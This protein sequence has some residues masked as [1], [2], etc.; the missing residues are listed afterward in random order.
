MLLLPVLYLL[1]VAGT[2]IAVAIYAVSGL[3]IIKGGSFFLSLLLYIGPLFAG[4]VVLLFL[5]KP[6]FASRVDHVPFHL[7]R[8]DE[9]PHLYELTE[10]LARLVGA[11]LPTAIYVSAR[12]N[13]SAGLHTGLVRRLRGRIFLDVGLP[14]VAGLSFL[15]FAGV[16]SHEFGHVGQ[17]GAMRLG[18]LIGAINAWFARAV[19]EEDA[20]DEQL[21][22]WFEGQ[23]SSGLVQLPA[24]L[25]RGAV[26]MTRRV[27]WLLMVAG[28]GLS[29]LLSR[30]M[31]RDADRY[32]ARLVGGTTMATT[33]QKLELLMVADLVVD[34]EIETGEL[35]RLPDDLPALVAARARALSPAVVR[36]IRSAAFSQETGFFDTHPSIR[37]RVESCTTRGPR[38]RE[39]RCARD[40]A[41]PG[42]SRTLQ[43]GHAGPLR[44]RRRARLRLHVGDR[45][46]GEET[47]EI[48]GWR[49]G[50]RTDSLFPGPG[51]RRLAVLSEKA[52]A[53]AGAP[54][55]GSRTQLEEFRSRLTRDLPAARE[56]D[57]RCSRAREIRRLAH[58]AAALLVAGIPINPRY[59]RLQAANP[60][61]LA[62][63]LE[64]A[65][66]MEQ[67]ALA[68]LRAYEQVQR[69]RLGVAL[70]PAASSTSLS[71]LG[72]LRRIDDRLTELQSELGCFDVLAAAQAELPGNESVRHHVEECRSRLCTRV[73]EMASQVGD[74]NYVF[75]NG[76]GSIPLVKHLVPVPPRQGEGSRAARDFLSRASALHGRL[77]GELAL[78]AEAAETTAGLPPLD[79]PRGN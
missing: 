70:L 21:V 8:R 31:E 50:G 2:G 11:P 65:R 72:A 55:R 76:S 1:I 67:G 69:E 19:Y 63:A 51:S 7:V 44:S 52:P 46:A 15:Q 34:D 73:E 10:R 24:L 39:D 54:P 62:A 29:C 68:D 49:P 43:A 79:P 30:E 27:L 18:R 32:E 16:M 40:R 71:I 25:A 64:R 37:D 77:L 20:W 5:L 36:R 23:S 22:D 78:I 6:L 47:R 41:L 75:P 58:Q 59:F 14:L 56:A 57:L 48:R 12:V 9:E 3:A 35:G 28:H 45:R 74:V 66:E 60:G 17:G 4:I 42:L 38:L 26:W 61:G 13:A 33:L 53:E